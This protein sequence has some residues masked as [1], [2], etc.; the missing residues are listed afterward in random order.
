MSQ[1]KPEI[2]EF[3]RESFY[4]K[5]WSSPATHLAKELGCSDVLIGKVCKEYMIP[6]PYLGYWAKL[7]H[8]K[9]AKK[10]PLPKCDDPELQTLVFRK[11]PER[12]T[13][14]LE[15]E[16]TYA[17]DLMAIFKKAR[18]MPAIK[19]K[20]Q[21]GTLHPYVDATR[22]HLRQ[23]DRA[24]SLLSQSERNDRRLTISVVT[25]KGKRTRAL[26]ILDALVRRIEKIGGSIVQSSGQDYYGH[27]QRRWLEVHICGESLGE[28]GIREKQRR[29]KVPEAERDPFE[30]A[31]KLVDTGNL[32]LT[33]G[34]SYGEITVKD[35]KKKQIE[36][37]LNDLIFA[38]I[39]KAALIR[40][41]RLEREEQERRRQEEA[42]R[43][44]RE[45][46]EL[47]QR[48]EE[49]EKRQQAEQGRVDQ[50]LDEVERRQLSKQV[51][52]Y[53]DEV[54]EMLMK[55]HGVTSIGLESDGADFFRWAHQQADR[56]DP[57]KRSPPSVL[58][59]RI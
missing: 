43:R 25:S 40:D 54:C 6:K 41:K 29:V 27:D 38:L 9:K 1:N 42:D 26:C 37:G 11:Y 33:V 53:L 17:P 35:T 55:R 8:K 57:L 36:D 58:D 18:G 10:T 30:P 47:K 51:R 7:R 28:L 21:L 49:L 48:R 20:K 32:V 39:R 44:H 15:A 56:I 3:T 59:E 14:A 22:D 34:P 16:S 45:E 31:S 5:V 23:G 19:V 46:Q 13:A 2:F 12:E 50:L 52:E 4:E 24:Y